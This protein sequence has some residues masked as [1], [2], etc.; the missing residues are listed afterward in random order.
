MF[1]LLTTSSQIRLYLSVSLQYHYHYY[2]YYVVVVVVEV[3]Q[4][5]DDVDDD[6]VMV[7]EMVI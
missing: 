3:G 6:A 2:C 5:V 7:L 1:W 4:V